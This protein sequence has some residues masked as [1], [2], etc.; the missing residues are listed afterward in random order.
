MVRNTY[1][2]FEIAVTGM[3]CRFPGASDINEFWENLK[4]GLDSVSS[5]SDQELKEYF[6]QEEDIT[7]PRYVKSKGLIEEADYFDAAF[8]GFS[9]KEANALDPQIRILAQTAYHALEDS[10]F[11][12]EK[13]KNNVGVFVGALPNV[14]WQLHCFK[15][16][17][18]QYSEQFS[19]LILNDK[20]FAA[21][22]LSYLLNLH[23]P[24]S[25]IYTACSTSLVTVD[26]ACQS[27][28][29]GK[30]DTA[31]AGGVALSLPYKSGYTH[32]E[33][34]IMSVDGHTRSF[35]A[36]A[37][38]TVWSDGVGMVVLKRLDDAL[39]D[40]DQIHAVIKGTH[41]NND[42]NRK[43]G[44]TAPSIQ[45]QVEVIRGALNMA[46]VRPEDIDYVEGHG[47]ATSLGDKIEISALTEVFETVDEGFKC[48]IGSVK[49]NIGHLNTA[50]GIAGFIKVCL[51][52]KHSQI[53]PT[54]HFETPN[55]SL[56]K[57]GC[58]FRVTNK[59]EEWKT[60][61]EPLR[62]GVS[63][64]GI[65]GTNAHVILE[66]API[67]KS[68]S[69]DT[70]K[71]LVLISANTHKSFE[72]LTNQLTSHITQRPSLPLDDLAYTLQ[73]GRQH[74]KYR[75]HFLVQDKDQLV[76]SISNINTAALTSSLGKPRIVMMFPGMGTI[77]SNLGKDLYLNEQVFRSALDECFELLFAK[78]GRNYKTFLFPENVSAF[79]DDFQTPQLLTFSVEYALSVLLKSWGIVPDCVIGYSLGEYVAACIAG[80]FTLDAALTILVQRGLLINSLDNGGMLSVPLS[81]ESFEPYLNEEIDIAIDNGMSIVVAGGQS[82][83]EKLRSAL[84]EKGIGTI[85]I[86]NSYALHSSNMKTILHEFENVLSNQRLNKPNV[87]IISNVTGMWC[88]DNITS[89]KYWTK[90]LSETIEFSKGIKT[91]IQEYPNAIYLE[92]GAG[93]TLGLL[94][95]RTGKELDQTIRSISLMKREKIKS[96]E[97]DYLLKSIGALW[98]FGGHV[99]W[100]SYHEGFDKKITSLIN[101]PF[102]RTSFD[103]LPKGIFD[104]VDIKRNLTRQSNIPSWFYV[105]SWQRRPLIKNLL[106]ENLSFRKIL[107]LGG[108]KNDLE[109]ANGNFVKEDSFIFA[110][111][112]NKFTQ[113][114]KNEFLLNFNRRE[115]IVSL[116]Q[117]IEAS[118]CEVDIIVDLL[119]VVSDQAHGISKLK[120]VVTL[121]QGISDTS[122]ANRELEYFLVAKNVC[123]INGLEKIDPWNAALL[124]AIKVIPQENSLIKCRFM[125]LDSSVNEQTTSF[126]PIILEE[127]QSKEKD[128]IVSYRG[129]NRWV[130]NVI[131]YPLDTDI[132]DS[133]IVKGG[134][135]VVVGG[136]GDIGFEI[137]KYL[138][139]YFEANLILIGRTS[140]PDKSKR[141]EWLDKNDETTNLG[142]KMLRARSLSELK[143]SVRFMSADSTV[144]EDM[145]GCFEEIISNF[146]HIEGVF[147]A[148]GSISQHAFNV[149][150]R[151]DEDQ[152]DF[153]FPVKT[154]GLDII[155]DLVDTYPVD[156]VCIISSLSSI[157]GGLGMVGYAAA[158]QYMDSVVARQNSEISSTSWMTFNFSNWQGWDDDFG[159]ITI[160]DS[161]LET[162][163]VP[164]DSTE[165]FNGLFSRSNTQAQV[166]ISPVDL[167]ALKE[168][169][170]NALNAFEAEDQN[171]EVVSKPELSN[172]YMEPSVDTERQMVELWEGIFG[173]KPIG[174]TDDFVELGGDS[175]MAVV[176]I[177]RIRKAF[178]INLE[179]RDIYTCT[180]IRL[181][182][183]KIKGLEKQQFV[184]IPKATESEFYP[185]SSAQQRMYFLYE[186]N[187]TSLA[188]N[189]LKAMKL[190]GGLDKK[191]LQSAFEE[192]IER[193]E[194]F[195]T[196]FLMHN[197]TT[198]QKVLEK[199][200]FEI[201]DLGI[202][203]DVNEAISKFVRPFDLEHPP[204]LR[205]GLIE[206]GINEYLLLI[207]LHHMIYDG[208]TITLLLREFMAIYKGEELPVLNLQY[209][210]YAVWQ[211]SEEQQ[212]LL[213]EQ[214]E[215]WLNVYSEEVTPLELPLDRGRSKSSNSG[216]VLEFQLDAKT[217]EQLS[218][219][220]KSEQ[221]TLFVIIHSIYTILLSKLSGNEDIVVGVPLAGRNHADL[222]NIAGLFVNTIALRSYPIGVKS[223]LEYLRVLKNSVMQSL[224]HQEYPFEELLQALN[225]KRNTNRP[226]LFDVMLD[227][228]NFKQPAIKMPDLEVVPFDYEMGV[229]IADLILYVD[230][231]EDALSLTF[232]YSTEL[233]EEI[234]ITRFVSYFQNIV[235]SI[236]ADSSVPLKDFKI[237]DSPDYDLLVNNYND[238]SVPLDYKS[239][240]L[241]AFANQVELNPHRIAAHYNDSSF[242]YLELDTRSNQ[243]ANYLVAKNVA[244]GDLV[245]LLL[246]RSLDIIV[247]ILGV[248][249]SGAA[250]LPIDPSLPEDRVSYM[251][252]QSS[253][254]ILLS[255]KDYSSRQF[256][257]LQ[258]VDI[259]DSLIWESSS[260]EC[261][262]KS[263]K[264]DLAY[265]IFTS[266]SSGKPK[267]VMMSRRSVSNLVDGL[268]LTVYKNYEPGLRVA[269]L[270][271]YAFDASVQQI[272]GSLILGHSLYITDDHSRKDGE[273]LLK[274]F[275]KHKIEISDGTP[276]HLRLLL[277]GL[278][279]GEELEYLKG[280]I[281]AGE[282]LDKELVTRFYE[283]FSAKIDLYNFY[284]PTETCVDSTYY[285]IDPLELSRYESIPIGKPLPNERIYV[286]DNYGNLVAPGV[287]G[288]LCIAGL[289]L[290][291]GYVGNQAMTSER[292]ISNWL[293]WED[294]VYRTG[295]LVRWLPDGNLKFIGRRDDQV[296]LRGYRIEL[297]EIANVLKD[298]DFIE[299]A[300]VLLDSER[301]DP[302]LAAYLVPSKNHAY[303]VRKILNDD[304]HEKASFGEL[305]EMD[306][307]VSMYFYN[308]SEAKILYTEIFENKTYH[309]HGIKIPKNA[310]IIDIGANV[311]AF[312]IFAMTRFEEPQI[313]AFEPVA[314]IFKLL[315]KNVSMY[316][317]DVKIFN[318][319]LSDKEESAVFDFYPNATTLSGRHSEGY[320]IQNEVE[321]FV[322][323]NQKKG[324]Q[325]SEIQMKELLDD[326]LIK[327]EH[328]CHLKSLSQIIIEE[329][330]EHIDLLKIDAENVELDVINGIKDSDWS[331][332][333][334]V[335]IE[336]YDQDGRLDLIV[337]KLEKLGFKVE[338]F[339]SDELISTKFY[340]VYC[341]KN[342]D[343]QEG[344]IVDV[345][346]KSKWFG[347]NALVT[348]VREQL[349]EKL[350]E[351]MVPSKIKLIEDVPLTNSGKLD[352]RALE[353]LE[354]KQRGGQIEDF[355]P[356]NEN[357][358]LMAS[359]W[360]EVLKLDKVG[361]YDNFYELGG[362]SIKAIQIAN[363]CKKKGI[364]VQ[365]K[366]LIKAQTIA[367]VLKNIGE[368]N[369]PSLKE[370]GLL[371]GDVPLHPI[372]KHFFDTNHHDA[373]HFNQAILLNLSKALSDDNIVSAI[374]LLVETH[375][376]LRLK[377]E[378]RSNGDSPVQSYGSELP[379]LYK[380]HLKDLRDVENI[381]NEYQ[382]NLNIS[383]GELVRFVLLK[384]SD[385]EFENKLLIVIHHIGIDAVSWRILIEDLAIILDNTLSGTDYNLP[386]KG[387][388][389]RQ[390]VSKLNE[391]LPTFENEEFYYWKD[392]LSNYQEL[393]TDFE[394]KDKT[395]FEKVRTLE[396]SLSSDLT[397][398]LVYEIPKTYGTELIDILISGLALS[399]K[400]MHDNKKAIITLEGHGR[401]SLF[402]DVDINRTVGWFTSVYPVCLNLKEVDDLRFLMSDIKDNLN[403]IP[404][405]GLGYNVLRYMSNDVEIRNELSINYQD[406]IFNY[407]GDLSNTLSQ[408]SKSLNAASES[409]GSR[410]SM[411]NYF[412]H[413]LAFNLMIVEGKLLVVCDYDSNRF[414]ESTIQKLMDDYIFSLDR[415]ISHCLKVS[416]QQDNVDDEQVYEVSFL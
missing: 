388:S 109:Y 216:A 224:E 228:L 145:K 211:Q 90:H 112:G 176:L 222:E 315:E 333:D 376:S 197:D 128:T 187:K 82:H 10:G 389:Y 294:R 320:E 40:G 310:T 350:P 37:T 104:S 256:A 286:T 210:D 330:I 188:Y 411:N 60:N 266:G 332:V 400:E 106:D 179:V 392:I 235:S 199:V 207:D 91:L 58:P 114:N 395:T 367:A 65:G 76:E 351:Y 175:L 150:E 135:Y 8:F 161:A 170:E 245:G 281:L 233:F 70:R 42:G 309:K 238:T 11:N 232:R 247:G 336:V 384:T 103:I 178:S 49:S 32:E 209:K 239:S 334:Q 271:S 194:I 246:D 182:V 110:Q 365:I 27:L 125:E 289:G 240:L 97:H 28:L 50:S 217:T 324:E 21:T 345:G 48:T 379:R 306:N 160:S 262:R 380:E 30:S 15:K 86:N 174:I 129:K 314:P 272:F 270:A 7:N 123:S 257:D 405:K 277:N 62:A 407:L 242:S 12:F 99:N 412:E 16:A 137:A 399:L 280:W 326:R 124:S 64:F 79:E 47:S 413:K 231:K 19:S 321:Q 45:G 261:K 335:I 85:E 292:F 93:N 169:W 132:K 35:D 149:V 282:Y 385:D 140:I 155:Q 165:L 387:T 38:G 403:S 394:F 195:R 108:N 206:L 154:I 74:L 236:L 130:E 144:L 352:R 386:A 223:Y 302:Q 88:N 342:K 241:S 390:W 290:G 401:E 354:E 293:E 215:F 184:S 291:E 201:H 221:T 191:R 173:F 305:F 360:Q 36:K 340:D 127:L 166:I 6:N 404:N 265:C 143:G 220:A 119:N 251:I 382:S 234:T 226:P 317:G 357:E 81:K 374:T 196:T 362:D 329:N 204:L 410:T 416:S 53:P 285:K 148:A 225:L 107:I 274:F 26:M 22:R 299:D 368:E 100:K 153:H 162:F 3:A 190:I 268:Q 288:E 138:L 92:M 193:H 133:Q 346:S 25:T 95:R 147:H 158:N 118:K 141:D 172:D 105:P 264:G 18:N 89:A 83:L 67:P 377:F 39:R 381:C 69:R 87:P 126:Y 214:K 328:T 269:L 227:Y 23:G 75:K 208:V 152:L 139:R 409:T 323:H 20:D 168:K 120:R 296:K 402:K 134:T 185:L 300:V 263:T 52:L 180:T 200:D 338:A 373:D 304:I 322:S 73:I 116:F 341:T 115:H 142:R 398:Q 98:Q 205:V 318:V 301:M 146:N 181:L 244:P 311:G 361:I 164:D 298:L 369:K 156:F 364:V 5:F 337:G 295:D 283:K 254:S 9:P 273:A 279:G 96:S 275:N 248:L 44:Y 339:Q 59:L 71:S 111:H 72:R 278:Q 252:E 391:R 371:K 157:L 136:L 297:G 348:S 230:E 267:G 121:I 303:T 113:K 183:S 102:E 393:Y 397:Q 13:S 249:K 325:L 415:I 213:R 276:T 55:A 343:I 219:L 259:N 353:S 80:V 319:G 43:V 17:G 101:Y 313:Y 77:Y 237:L 308:R 31:L 192:L 24:S 68:T 163:I 54:V 243:L 159:E 363:K 177:N 33:G 370:E 406:I 202:V 122:H 1:T 344:K 260:K 131:P 14:N 347:S 366:D 327:E 349:F 94:A 151:I 375:D 359:I 258:V 34:M 218:V 57:Q 84:D 312:S 41:V 46:D 378:S 229:T 203:T 198:V 78:T 396:S 4:S 253:T 372:Q 356:T 316:E 212:E 358:K 287:I 355:E 66:K 61:F 250:Y 186:Y 307:G 284:G 414:K 117:A 63:S 29:T 167:L 255:E 331:K 383:K 189:T 171:L 408:K 2:G 51:M 56:L